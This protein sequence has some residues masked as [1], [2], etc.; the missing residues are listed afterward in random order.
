MSV[1]FVLSDLSRMRQATSA[2]RRQESWWEA[3][4]AG[5]RIMYF[6]WN[7]GMVGGLYVT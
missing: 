4:V 5:M 2:M 6:T 7:F 3:V 1:L